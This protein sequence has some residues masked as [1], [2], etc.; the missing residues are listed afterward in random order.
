MDPQTRKPIGPLPS[1][2]SNA[3]CAVMEALWVVRHFIHSQALPTPLLPFHTTQPFAAIQGKR[4]KC[5]VPRQN[6]LPGVYPLE[7]YAL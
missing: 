1:N 5:H 4:H 6:T 3:Y 2:A 7:G